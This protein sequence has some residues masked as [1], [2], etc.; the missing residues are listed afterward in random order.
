MDG[1]NS[2]SETRSNA[3]PEN[4]SKLRMKKAETKD[5]PKIECPVD[6][7]KITSGQSLEHKSKRSRSRAHY[8]KFTRGKDVNRYSTKDLANIFG[9]KNLDE[10][11]KPE[12]KPCKPEP[13]S[14]I[15]IESID[16]TRGKLQNGEA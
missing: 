15:S 11:I 6:K 5:L 8:Q 9:E 16:T 1:L 13:E 4:K 14:N 3:A 12:V 10:C 2:S 7:D